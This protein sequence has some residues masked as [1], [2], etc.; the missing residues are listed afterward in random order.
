LVID[1]TAEDNVT[2]LLADYARERAVPFMALWGVEGF[3][4][5][6]ARLVPRETGCYYCLELH[7]SP[8]HGANVPMPAPPSTIRRVQPRGCADPTFTA[9]SIDLL[10]IAN[11]AA[12][13]AFGELC[14]GVEAGYPRY[15][16]DVHV[17][18]V[19]HPDGSLVEPPE[20][21]SFQLSIHPE[22]PC[23]D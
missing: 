20:W 8:E 6:V 16:H 18:S 4:G 1:A 19:R 2:A 11:Q 22:C 7:M 12:R 17:L 21:R 14:R 9:P 3:G 15:R 5:A 23:H 13:A 10:P